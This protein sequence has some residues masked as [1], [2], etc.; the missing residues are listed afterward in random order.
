MSGFG[1]DLNQ[2]EKSN[3]KL[4]VNPSSFQPIMFIYI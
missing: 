4:C 2:K 1:L 3:Q